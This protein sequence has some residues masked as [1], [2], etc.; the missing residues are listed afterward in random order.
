MRESD[1]KDTV[2][3]DPL[4]RRLGAN[5]L[6][7]KG[8]NPNQIAAI[9]ARLGSLAKLLL[10][11]RQKVDGGG[12]LTLEMILRPRYFDVIIASVKHV[13][14]WELG[15]ELNPPQ[16][17]V[18]SLALKL[19]HAL[20]KA[21]ELAVS[22][23]IKEDRTA[24]VGELSAH[25]TLHTNEWGDAVS[26]AALTTMDLRKMNSVDSLPLTEDMITLSTETKKKSKRWSGH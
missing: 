10:C 8:K 5:M 21:A 12:H 1:I 14:A 13:C 17:E 4:L 9:K 2:T 26:H 22:N 7:N 3:K 15:D 6:R 16:F 11:V 24:D 20:K 25:L 18:P 23:G 19:G